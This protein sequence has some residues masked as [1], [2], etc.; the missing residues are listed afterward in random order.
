VEI[1]SFLLPVTINQRALC[2]ADHTSLLLS[3]IS[4]NFGTTVGEASRE[5]LV[6]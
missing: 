6:I 2:D 3:Q 1:E 5:Q 4:H